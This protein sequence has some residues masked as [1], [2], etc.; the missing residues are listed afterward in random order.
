VINY[1]D[2]EK[3]A[4]TKVLANRM[5]IK[6]EALEPILSKMLRAGMIRREDGRR[7][8]AGNVIDLWFVP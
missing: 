6:I 3:G 7:K 1:I 5:K 8:R 2:P 4:S